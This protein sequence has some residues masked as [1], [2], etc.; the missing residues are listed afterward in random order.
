MLKSFS[1][2]VLALFCWGMAPLFGKLGLGGLEPLTALTIRSAV[3]T[4]LLALA[5]TAGGKWSAVLAA[6][7]RDVLF[8]AL[9]GVCAALL[10][11]LAYYYALKYGEVGRVSPVVSAFPLVALILA[12]VFFGEKITAGKAAGAVLIVAGI[13]LLRY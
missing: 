9:E 2:A 1:F 6:A 10:G 3:V 12:A 8:V 4:G 5:V 7:P 13:I 11:Q